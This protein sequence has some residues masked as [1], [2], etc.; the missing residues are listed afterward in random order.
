MLVF[1]KMHE[2]QEMPVSCADCPF[3][4]DDT[5]HIPLARRRLDEQLLKPY[6]TKRHKDCPLVLQAD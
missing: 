5:C 3:W 2:S 4:N 1:T 6:L